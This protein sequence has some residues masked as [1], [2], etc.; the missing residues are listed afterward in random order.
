MPA[1]LDSSVEQY[2][3]IEARGPE[4]HSE[5]FLIAYFDEESLRPLIARP[6]I[7]ARGIASREQAQAKIDANFSAAAAEEQ[8][9]RK[10]TVDGD[11]RLPVRAAT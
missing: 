9:F 6:S 4:T 10:V 8:T 2:A 3:V 1:V 5:F 11:P 7:A